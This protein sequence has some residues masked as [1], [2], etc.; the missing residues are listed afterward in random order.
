MPR[1]REGKHSPGMMNVVA[2][3]PK[4]KKSYEVLVE[5]LNAR[6]DVTY[7]CNDEAGELAASSETAV[8]AGDDPEHECGDQE[9]LDLN[10]L[11]AEEL[12]QGD[13]DEVSWNIACDSDDQVADRSENEGVV[14]GGALREADVRKKNRL[15]QV[16]T[17]ERH[18]DEEPG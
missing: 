6:G 5:V 7:L 2:L 3:G 12:D 13:G 11:S 10:P 14:L 16:D 8:V 9:T 17:V 18:V 1:T 4:L 15:V